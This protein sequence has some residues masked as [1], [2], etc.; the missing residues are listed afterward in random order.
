[1]AHILVV[2]DEEGIRVLITNI[3]V[4]EG[5]DVA[6]AR[7]GVEALAAV[8]LRVPDLVITDLVMPEKEGI[9]M[10]IE[11][12]KKFPTIKTIAMSGGGT[13][14]IADYLSIAL[15]V[16]AGQIVS[17]PFTRAALLAAVNNLVTPAAAK[18]TLP[19]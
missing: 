13:T 16:G 3:L 8:A 14:G 2:D 6:T 4:R 18:Q 7:N 15:A 1:M 10:I 19:A 12:R 9:E 17:K 5:H 11:L